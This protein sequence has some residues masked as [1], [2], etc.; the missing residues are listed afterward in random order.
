M[1]KNGNAIKTIW[2]DLGNVILDFDFT[3]A[4][5]KLTRY[6][7]RTFAEIQAYFHNDPALEHDLDVGKVPGL[8]LFRR[9]VR[10]L[11]I[12]GLTFA[13]FRD[14]WNKI[15]EPNPD[16]VRLLGR[17]SRNGY[18][19]VLIS[20][21]N[22]LHYTH[23]V[24]R[25]P[26]LRKY[27]HR[28]ILSYKLKVRKPKPGIYQRAIAVSRAACCEIFYTDDRSEMTAAAGKNHGVV[29][30]TFRGFKGLVRELVRAG[31]KVD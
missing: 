1:K 24:K 10:D 12:R 5:R 17:L 7:G 13:E 27:F 31:V 29:C 16:M 18:R 8:A 30:H 2:F 14:I 19:L 25:Y 11:D 28:H 20:N 9:L 22:H 6:T 15:F 26:F 3:P 21:T 23:I 4:Y